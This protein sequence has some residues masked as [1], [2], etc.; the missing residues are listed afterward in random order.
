MVA[1]ERLPVASA[2]FD[3]NEAIVYLNTNRTKLFE[4]IKSQRLKSFKYG[5]GRRISRE[6]CDA[7]IAELE[8]EV[9]QPDTTI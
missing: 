2:V 6:A 9:D 4:L 7:L 8:S 1:I 5:K 3:V